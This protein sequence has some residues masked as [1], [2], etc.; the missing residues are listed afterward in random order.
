MV[1]GGF[2]ASLG[3]RRIEAERSG[4]TSANGFAEVSLGQLGAVADFAQV[5]VAEATAFLS[6]GHSNAAPTP[7]QS[8]IAV[9]NSCNSKYFLALILQYRHPC[10]QISS[11]LKLLA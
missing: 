2:G 9:L 10:R 3:P 11:L 6:G 7:T 5:L 4:K 1:P 8:S